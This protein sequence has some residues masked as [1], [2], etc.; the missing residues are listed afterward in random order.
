HVFS[1]ELTLFDSKK[2]L[3]PRVPSYWIFD[4]KRID[5]GALPRRPGPRAQY[6]KYKW[7]EDNSEELDRG[8]IKQAD[9]IKELALNL[10][11][12]SQTLLKTV[13]NYNIYCK[14]GVDIEFGREPYTLLPLSTPPYYAVE[15]WPGGV[16]TQGGPRRNGKAQVLRV[17]G[18]PIPRLYSTGELG[19]IYGML[20]PGGG[21][22]LAE[23][24]AFG[25]IAGENASQCQPL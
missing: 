1:Y 5:A 18:S 12:E 15:L 9:T 4:Q 24:F 7:S 13:N 22:N 14:N 3:Y 20:Y 11:M 8:W 10:G 23:C 19:S 21:G 25:R 2:L 17:D 6:H 16:N